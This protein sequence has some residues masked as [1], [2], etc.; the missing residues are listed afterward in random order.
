M[1]KTLIILLTLIGFIL[2]SVLLKISLAYAFLAMN[3]ILLIMTK[4]RNKA[5]SFGFKELKKCRMIYIIILLLGANIALWM[6]SGIL[7]TLVYYS[8]TVIEKM[9]FLLV[10]FLSVTLVSTVMGTGLGTFSTIGLVFIALSKPLGYPLPVVVGAIVS[11][12]FI[13]DKISPVSALTNLTIE[14]TGVSYKAYA[15]KAIVTLLP[16]IVITALFYTILNTNYS[17]TASVTTLR[18][19]LPN[20]Y[21]ISGFLLIV[22]LAMMVLSMIGVSVVKN[23]LSVTFAT[24]I[25]SLIYQKTSLVFLLKSM[26][27]GYELQ[28]KS[29][30]GLNDIITTIFKGGGM[31]PM[32]EVLII[33][34]L[35]VFMTGLFTADQVLTPL[36]DYLMKNTKNSFQL[37]LKTGILSFF[38][39]SLTCDQTVGIVVPGEVLKPYYKVF[40]LDNSLLARTISDT[41]TIMA[42]LEFWNVNVLIISGLVGINSIQYAP[43]AFLLWLAPVVTLLF[44][45]FTDY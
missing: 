30:S 41:G 15:K 35:V 24:S 27:F 6:S 45:K 34:T 38:L 40:K 20:Y 36:V 13:S 37:V 32:L 9:N 14:I 43:Y 44:A 18:D 3:I 25:I 5:I 29:T 2:T 10:T 21:N 42:P 1:K 39:N 12:A 22:P 31:V 16:T 4:H 23:M 28:A 7:P 8:A 17:G 11:G 33:V 19:A 26:I